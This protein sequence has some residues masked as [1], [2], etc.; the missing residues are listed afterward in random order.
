MRIYLFYIRA[1]LITNLY[2]GLF[3]HAICAAIKTNDV[4]TCRQANF[5]KSFISKNVCCIFINL[6][7]KKMLHSLILH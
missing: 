7:T 5:I 4:L 6:I 2:P 3:A 1:E